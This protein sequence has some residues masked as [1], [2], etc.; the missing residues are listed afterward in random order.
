MTHPSSANLYSVATGTA[1]TAPFIEIFMAR[2]PEPTDVQGPQGQF[3]IQQ[4]WW[5][6]STGSEWVL[7]AFNAF[8]GVISA[9][10]GQVG[11][12]SSSSE[13]FIVQ[14]GTS[15]VTP[16]GSNQITFSG[17]TNSAGTTP[18]HTEGSTNTM[19]LVVQLAQ[20]NAS[21]NADIAGLSSFNSADFTVDDNGYVSAVSSG[22]ARLVGVDTH[23]SP[24]TDPVVP[25]SGGLITVTGG[26]VA[27]GTTANVIQTDSTAAS[28]Y[29]IEIQ[30][31]QAV[32]SSTVGD[33]GVSHFNSADFTVDENGFV[34]FDLELALSILLIFKHSQSWNLHPIG[35]S[36]LLQSAISRSRRGR[37]G[38]VQMLQLVLQVEAVAEVMQSS[39]LMPLLSVHQN[40]L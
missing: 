35:W 5:N 18:V 33:N 21:S 25:T 28:E 16:N 37:R 23:F 38:F 9:V 2:D 8:N 17:T 36:C 10:W 7:T 14:A 26:Q 40:Q 24:G 39:Y 4:R 1:N 29:T 11:S 27:A 3:Q 19:T 32:A 20:A 31:S 6:T 15:P 12:G 30:R 22:Y 13:S 34:S